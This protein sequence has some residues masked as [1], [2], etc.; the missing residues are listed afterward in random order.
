MQKWLT[1]A[2]VRIIDNRT[3]NLDI[4]LPIE[5]RANKATYKRSKQ[6]NL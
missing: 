5:N 4:H 1:Q 3:H 2:A 6:Y